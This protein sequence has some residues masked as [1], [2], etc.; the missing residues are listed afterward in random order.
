ML[1]TLLAAVGVQ[2]AAQLTAQEDHRR[3]LLALGIASIR[4]GVDGMHPSAPNFANTDEAKANPYPDIPDVMAFKNGRS[5]KTA[6]DW[7]RRRSEIIED[8]DREIY[9][10]TPRNLPRVTWEVRSTVNESNGAV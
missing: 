8:L 9:G 6:R 4:P 3:L 1:I 7:R 5:V 2:G 10:R